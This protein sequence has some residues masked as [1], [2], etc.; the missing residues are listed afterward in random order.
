[1]SICS[2]AIYKSIA[3][4][5]PSNLFSRPIFI[6]LMWRVLSNHGCGEIERTRVIANTLRAFSHEAGGFV[7]TSIQQYSKFRWP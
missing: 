1:M 5:Q 7:P 3:G 4:Q 6:A 2:T